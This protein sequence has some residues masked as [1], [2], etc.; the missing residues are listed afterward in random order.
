MRIVKFIGKSLVWIGIISILGF[1]VGREVLLSLGV[2]QLKSSLSALKSMEVKKTYFS[3]CQAKGVGILQESSGAVLQIRFTSPTEYRVEIL[4]SEFSFDPIIVEQE[5]LPFLV[6]KENK[7]G[8]I[9]WGEALSGVTLEL[10]GRKKTIGVSERSIVRLD[11]DQQFV[12]QPATTCSG[13]GFTCCQLESEQ[14]ANQQLSQGVTDCPRSCFQS[15][16]A[17]PVILS[18]NTEPVLDFKNRTVNLESGQ[19]LEFKFVIDPGEGDTL[20]AMLDYGDGETQTFDQTDNQATH[21]YECQRRVCEYRVQLSAE[22]SQGITSADLPVT[23]L[24][25]TVKGAL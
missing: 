24:G 14:G 10:W 19:S 9:I 13:H 11:E 2:S 23:T 15:C 3:Q 17:R 16:R 6:K 4:C 1:L 18:F 5:S 25:V 21:V 22:N 12:S 7:S 20:H 8:G